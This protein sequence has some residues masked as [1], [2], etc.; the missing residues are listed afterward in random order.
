MDA[1][2]KGSIVDELL[3]RLSDIESITDSTQYS[4][5]LEELFDGEHALSQALATIINDTL[6]AISSND[7]ASL[8]ENIAQA[9]TKALLVGFLSERY[10][11][12]KVLDDTNSDNKTL[13]SRV[14]IDIIPL[15]IPLK[16]FT[17]L[18]Y[19][20]NLYIFF[21]NKAARALHAAGFMRRYCHKISI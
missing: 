4:H 10:V 17:I 20:D 8:Q 19:K 18:L 13:F 7:P 3:N 1:I 11:R 9:I 21:L 5:I 15:Y 14:F 2:I 12:D 16:K 6:K